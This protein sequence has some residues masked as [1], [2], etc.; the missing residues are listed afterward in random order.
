MKKF[1]YQGI[2]PQGMQ[3]EGWIHAESLSDAAIKLNALGVISKDICLADENQALQNY[4]YNLYPHWGISTLELILLFSQ[5]ESLSHAGV[6]IRSALQSIHDTSENKRLK[7]ILYDIIM[8][9]ESG[10]PL[11]DAMRL[12]SGVF[13]T[14]ITSL[15][16]IGEKTGSL[17]YA[18]CQIKEYLEEDLSAKRQL[19]LAL[20]YPL[21][22]IVT[23]LVAI[24]ILN[25]WVIPVFA[26]FFNSFSAELPLPTKILMVISNFCLDYKSSLL[27]AATMLIGGLI[28]YYRTPS[29]R[30]ALGLQKMKLPFVGNLIKYT[31]VAQF[32][33][34]L[35][36][37]LNANVPILSALQVIANVSDNYYFRTKINLIRQSIEAG[38][39]LSQ[40][41]T[42]CK[43][44][45]PILIQMVAV[46]EQTGDLEGS[47]SHIAQFYGKEVDYGLKSLAE[48]MEPVLLFI[49]AGMVLVLALG[50]FLPMWDISTVAM[51][52]IR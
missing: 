28:L 37:A 26:E 50:V 32:C 42:H 39:S 5:L 19:K 49:I 27:I 30:V 10:Y 3:A 52:S 13:N 8:N 12:Y 45:S 35:S 33:G 46:G 6:N 43:I 24:I 29:G 17:D 22:V 21:F 2:N 36:H 4:I 41:M 48:K 14:F 9:V 11:S 38:E 40:A 34:H 44:F 31:L 23:L 1:F 18:F 7:Q 15:V 47:L 16:S 51:Q 25:F 20:R